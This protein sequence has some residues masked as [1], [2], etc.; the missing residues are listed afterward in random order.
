LSLSEKQLEEALDMFLLPAWQ[1][2]I[3]EVEDQ[4]DLITIDSCA[5]GNDL[6]YNKGRLAVLRMFAGFEQYVRQSIEMDDDTL[7]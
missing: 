3:E 4:M 2:L 7:Q 6:F 1:R 5:D